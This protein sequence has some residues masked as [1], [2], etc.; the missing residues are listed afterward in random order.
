MIATISEAEAIWFGYNIGN[1]TIS[2][3]DGIY[4]LLESAG[5][6]REDIQA[7]LNHPDALE[8]CK[9]YIGSLSHAGLIDSDNCSV[10]DATS[11]MLSGV[12]IA[13][14]IMRHIL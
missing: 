6:K 2:F 5:Y 9:N 8:H 14:T 10:I 13:R 4:L 1:K 12:D 11:N 7:K 3:V